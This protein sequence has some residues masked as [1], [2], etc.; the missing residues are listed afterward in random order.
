MGNDTFSWSVKGQHCPW[1]NRRDRL[2]GAMS[3][4]SPISI[5][6]LLSSSDDASKKVSV[7]GID[8]EE[9]GLMRTNPRR[10]SSLKRPPFYAWR[11]HWM[12]LCAVLLV[13]FVE[14]HAFLGLRLRDGIVGSDLDKET[15][16]SLS[17]EIKHLN[18]PHQ[19]FEK[20]GM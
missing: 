19:D 17:N 8:E 11:A 9:K 3:R 10:L 14:R 5:S 15:I 6:L 18:N 13:L 2:V 16:F 4:R 1:S 7:D 20:I 12:V